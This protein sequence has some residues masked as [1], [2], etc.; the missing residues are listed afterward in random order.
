MKKKTIVIHP[1]LF[2]VFPILFLYS[3]NVDEVRLS[4]TVGPVLLGIVLTLLLL[5]G[6]RLLL[7]NQVKAGIAVSLFWVL[8]FSF[9]RVYDVVGERRLWHFALIGS[10]SDLLL[11]WLLL[12]II[13]GYC[14]IT[15]RRTLR[16][17]TRICNVASL[18]LIMLSLTN[19]ALFAFKAVLAPHTTGSRFQEEIDEIE[20]RPVR[21][22]P[23][24]FYI[25]VDGYARED[26]LSN[27][28]DFDNGAFLDS[29]REKGFYVADKSSANYCQTT[30]SL[31]SSLNVNYLDDLVP[32]VGTNSDN[33]EP[34]CELIQQNR[35]VRILRKSGYLFTAFATGYRFTEVPNADRYL[36][37]GWL[38]GEFGNILLSTTPIPDLLSMISRYDPYETHRE[39]LRYICDH[40][41]DL[42]GRT[43]P[44][45]VFAH[46]MAPHPPFVF[47][48]DGEHITPHRSFALSDG[49]HFMRLKG[50]SRDEYISHYRGQ[51]VIREYSNTKV[52]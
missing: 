44:H 27:I 11:L 52:R 49:S 35:V 9:T 13:G 14:V 10:P 31:A 16:N 40:I 7:R 8:F 4:E 24:I 6:F 42:A 38:P 32:L 33:R 2:A 46:I 18:V 1:F 21:E 19:V 48:P 43:R 23:H 25:I 20:I 39:L 3:H 17:L 36:S 51:P 12:S 30:F 50:A 28:Y 29:L 26:I 41:D 5:S 45:F 34:L 37:P 22:L 47:G 15:T